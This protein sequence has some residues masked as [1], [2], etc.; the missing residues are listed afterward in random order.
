MVNAMT[1]MAIMLEVQISPD[2]D[3]IRYSVKTYSDS[4]T[5]NSD[6]FLMIGLPHPPLSS[7][8]L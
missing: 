5:I 6:S 7:A 1:E 3:S 2:L 4:R 8:T